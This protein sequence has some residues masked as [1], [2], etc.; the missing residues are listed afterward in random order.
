MKA[1]SGIFGKGLKY[2]DLIGKGG[3]DLQQAVA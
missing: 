1:V 3:D 2:V